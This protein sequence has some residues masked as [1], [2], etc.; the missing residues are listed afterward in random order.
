MTNKRF[1][2]LNHYGVPKSVYDSEKDDVLGIGE[3]VGLLN[4]LHKENEQLR[5]QLQEKQEDII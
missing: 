3:V 5:Q 4:T 1:E 2:V